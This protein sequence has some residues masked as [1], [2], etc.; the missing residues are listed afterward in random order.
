MTASMRIALVFAATVILCGSMQGQVLYGSLTG[1]VTDPSSAAIVH[2]RV[3]A[4]NVETGVSHQTETDVH[5]V[6][7]FTNLQLGNYKLT[8]TAPGFQTAIG[9]NVS[10]AP[11]E[12]RRSDFKLGIATS[13]Q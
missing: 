11:N 12:V 3:E 1:N 7:L 4:L 13:T 5:G 8:I 9:N 2:A 10:V 6:Y